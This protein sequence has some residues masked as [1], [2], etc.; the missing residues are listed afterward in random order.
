MDRSSRPLDELTHRHAAVRERYYRLV[1]DEAENPVQH[2]RRRTQLSVSRAWSAPQ[3]LRP[4]LIKL[5]HRNV[6]RLE[7]AMDRAERDLTP[8]K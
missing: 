3:L 8:P 1:S 7:R 2:L 5:A 6:T 4:L